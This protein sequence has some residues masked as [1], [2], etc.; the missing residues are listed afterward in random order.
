[1]FAHAIQENP[2]E[3]SRQRTARRPF[4]PA[5]YPHWN[6]LLTF[7]TGFS[8]GFM[9]K[10]RGFPQCF[11]LFPPSFPPFWKRSV[12]PVVFFQ[13]DAGSFWGEMEG[14][15]LF[16]KRKSRAKIYFSRLSAPGCF[17]PLQSGI[18]EAAVFHMEEKQKRHVE[19]RGKTPVLPKKR[20]FDET[21]RSFF[22]RITSYS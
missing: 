13:A 4:F 14:F 5:F 15:F 12:I 19:K 10:K 8:T 2:C 11:P 1:M 17:Q 6:H 18:F 16:S 9:K 20:S 3:S 7:S 22:L 21:H